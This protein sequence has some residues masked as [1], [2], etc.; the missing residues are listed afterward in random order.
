MISASLIYIYSMPNDDP[1]DDPNDTSG[2]A[3]A[4]TSEDPLPV[5]ETPG[6]DAR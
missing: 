6:N 1:N 4:E 5:D 2:N 3:D